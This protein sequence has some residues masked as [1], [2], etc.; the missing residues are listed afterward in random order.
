MGRLLTV[1][2]MLDSKFSFYLSVKSHTQGEIKAQL[3]REERKVTLEDAGILGQVETVGGLMWLRS[4]G[5]GAARIRLMVTSLLL[6][7]C[8]ILRSCSESLGLRFLFWEM[9]SMI[10]GRTRAGFLGM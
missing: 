6:A 5:S 10:S 3:W 7:S 9:G 2:D 8:A 1:D 4:Q